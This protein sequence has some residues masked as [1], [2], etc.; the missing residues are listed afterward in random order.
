MKGYLAIYDREQRQFHALP[1]ADDPRFVQTNATWSPDGKWI[2]FA[3]S[4]DR[5]LDPAELTGVKELVVP[6]EAAEDFVSKGKKFL[7][8][9]YR[10]PF[11]GGKG[12][13]AAPILGASNNGMSNYF[14]KFSPD[15]K[16]I[17][18]C[19]AKSFMLLQPDSELWIIPAEGGE[20]RP[21]RC[22]TSRMNSWHSWS[23]NGRWLVFSSKVNTP[24]TQLFLT[25]MD[26][27]GNS[28]PAVL[29]RQFTPPDRAANIP[30]FVNAPPGAIAKIREQFLNEEFEL[31]LGSRSAYHGD[32]DLAIQAY[33]KALEM[34]PK[35]AAAYEAWGLVLEHENKLQEAEAM[36]TKASALKPSATIHFNLGRIMGRLH[37]IPEAMQH[38]REAI[39]LDPASPLPYVHLACLLSD[40]GNLQE[41]KQ[42]L[43][44]ALRLDPRNP[45]A[46][47]YLG[48]TLSR[49]G[50]PDQAAAC[51]RRA[52]AVNPGC[53]PA[54]LRLTTLLVK[55][56]NAT[57]GSRDE[58]VTL[59][60]GV[61]H[62]ARAGR[63]STLSAGGRIRAGRPDGRCRR[64]GS[65]GQARGPAKIEVRS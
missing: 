53:V 46:Q 18:Y 51:F 39:R 23:P 45:L 11:N 12:G 5:A 37:K 10:I 3:R 6:A 36:L 56:Q 64:C 1:G 33:Q 38:H 49:D 15:G 20:A 43:A 58:A 21:L 27:A 22:N 8:D 54:L 7:Y 24:Y 47:A 52:L 13:V 63:G 29:L 26:E 2:V 30:E 50:Q 48:I 19:R 28:T 65:E 14:P 25:H 40:A 55:G 31:V 60:P 4:R 34:N 16:W 61:R 62:H 42:H 59:A 17:V 35:S 57:P 44:E 41:A 9:L 32:D